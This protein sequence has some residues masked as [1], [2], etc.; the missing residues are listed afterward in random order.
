MDKK[1]LAQRTMPNMRILY[2]SEYV[3]KEGLLHKIPYST[4]RSV[5]RVK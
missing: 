5:K 3:Q 2:K 1:E 4:H